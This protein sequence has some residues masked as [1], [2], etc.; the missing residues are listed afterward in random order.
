MQ[1]SEI[2]RVLDEVADL[3]ELQDENPF[4]VRAYRNAARTV[5]DSGE[6]LADMV[7]AERDLTELPSIGNDM[8]EK[9]AAIVTTGSLPL[10]Q[11]LAAKIPAG[12]LDLMRIPGL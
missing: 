9:I 11:Q 1:N 7:A 4:R 6:A 12:L 2:A 3:L 10:H 5:R 8:A